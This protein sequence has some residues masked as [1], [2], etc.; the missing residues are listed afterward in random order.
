MKRLGRMYAVLWASATFAIAHLAGDP[1]P[2]RA[3]SGPGCVEAEFFPSRGTVPANLPAVLF[4]PARSADDDAA[5]D[6]G[7]DPV[8][9]GDVRFARLGATGP[10]EVDFEL[11]PSHERSTRVR[12]GSEGVL[13]Y[14]IVPAAELQP[15]ARYA[16]WARGCSGDIGTEPPRE[17]DNGREYVDFERALDPHAPY[18]VFDVIAAAA[19]PSAL[20]SVMVSDP[21]R[22]EVPIGGGGACYDLYEASSVVAE[23]E[24]M[25]DPFFDAI[26]FVTYVDGE[27][28][29]PSAHLNHAPAYGDSWIGHGRDV[30]VA[31]CE[32][33]ISR[34]LAV[35]RHTLHFEGQVA[36]TDVMLVGETVDFELSCAE[37]V[38]DGGA[39]A[40]R[41]AGVFDAGVDAATIPIDAASRSPAVG[42]GT[43]DSGGCAVSGDVHG[44]VLVALLALALALRRRRRMLQERDSILTR[45]G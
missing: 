44:D 8:A 29:R 21:V 36:G 11:V 4:W 43:R 5:A 37:S 18:A 6:G 35:G 25:G 40:P 19:L 27:V 9:P 2:A 15:G 33:D 16:L 10:V 22:R 34:G 14:R 41:D 38:D 17:P 31:L 45:R 39:V 28:Y 7:L 20:G 30:L 42:H 24:R 1:A 23:V 26:A 32:I 13:A 3:C 12:A